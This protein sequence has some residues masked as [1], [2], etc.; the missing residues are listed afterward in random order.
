MQT[1]AGFG[2]AAS[3]GHAEQ[4][5]PPASRQPESP[6]PR[7]RRRIVEASW[8]C[9]GGPA[10]S[11]GARSVALGRHRHVSVGSGSLSANEVIN[12]ELQESSRCQ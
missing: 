11:R 2:E 7:K 5:A 1:E 9:G 3:V 4:A 6:P 10:A 12:C 8:L